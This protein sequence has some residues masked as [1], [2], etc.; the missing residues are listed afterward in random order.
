MVSGGTRA[1]TLTVYAAASLQE[2]LTDAAN[3][4]AAQGHENPVISFAASSA[5]ARQIENGAPA[6]LFISADEQWMDYLSDRGMLVPGTRKSFLGNTLVL[7]APAE[8]PFTIIIKSNFPIAS[9]LGTEKLA[10]ADPDSVPAGK[11]AKAALINLGVW[12]EIEKNVVPSDNVRAALAFVERN[13]ARAGVVYST[14]AMASKKVVVAGTF[15]AISHQPISY[16]IAIL[17]GHDTPEARAFREFL[18]S[19]P[20]K[21]IFKA[22]GFI[23]N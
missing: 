20:G 22:R 19:A 6:A 11:Y 4:Y 14:D 8:R 3:T 1:E 15:P 18:L 17:K 10:L 16:P 13:E 21:A 12:S 2:A 9:I 7:V 5:L 23:V